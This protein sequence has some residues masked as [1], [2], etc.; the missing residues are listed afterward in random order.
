MHVL[1]VLWDRVTG[2]QPQPPAWLI[3][4][5]GLAAVVIVLNT[6]I[7]RLTGKDPLARRRSTWPGWSPYPAR[8]RD[9]RHF[10]R[11]Y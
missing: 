4:L 8:Y 2:I 1:A 3:G 7:W 10:E 6:Q 5:T 11:M 9:P